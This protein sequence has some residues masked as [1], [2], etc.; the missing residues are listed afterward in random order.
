MGNPAAYLYVNDP[1]CAALSSLAWKNNNDR[2]VDQ[3]FGPSGQD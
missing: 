3:I 1:D 2:V